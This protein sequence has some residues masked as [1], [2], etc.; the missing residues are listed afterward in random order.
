DCCGYL[1]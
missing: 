1:S